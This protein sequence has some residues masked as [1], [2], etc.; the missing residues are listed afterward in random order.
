MR[1][2]QPQP[3]TPKLSSPNSRI[4][5]TSAIMFLNWHPIVVLFLS[6]WST[7]D[8]RRPGELQCYLVHLAIG[9]RAKF[10][11]VEERTRR[12]LLEIRRSYS[13][14]SEV[15]PRR[16]SIA[17]DSPSQC[18][19]LVPEDRQCISVRFNPKKLQNQAP[20][21]DSPVDIH[22]HQWIYSFYMYSLPASTYWHIPESELVI[23]ILTQ[24]PN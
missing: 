23:A 4:R 11:D 10:Q 19:I 5:S 24:Q 15:L 2:V 12:C 22:Q 20:K 3:T 21:V 1:K 14:P 13:L 16:F 17:S 8:G 7:K 9:Q 6:V 18:T